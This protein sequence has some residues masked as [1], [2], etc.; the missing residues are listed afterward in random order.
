MGK[1]VPFGLLAVPSVLVLL[2][3][4]ADAGFASGSAEPQEGERRIEVAGEGVVHAE[5]D[6]AQVS[7]G[8]ETFAPEVAAAVS[9]NQNLMQAVM[10]AVRSDGVASR[11]IQTVS[12]DIHFERD[13]QKQ[14]GEP[15]SGT[16]RVVNT[17]LVTVRQLDALPSILGSAVDAGANMIGGIQFGLADPGRLQ[18]EARS[19]AMQDALD[20]A[21]QLAKLAGAVVGPAIQVTEVATPGPVGPRLMAEGFGGGGPPVSAGQLQVVVRVNVAFAID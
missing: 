19:R 1:N 21:S 2:L 15:V 3:A 8:V 4:A 6:V 7:L 13:F 20:K 18:A 5:P 11:D 17:V 12:Y 9:R 16:Y 14:D 10:A